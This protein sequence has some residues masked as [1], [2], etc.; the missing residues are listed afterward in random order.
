[1][2]LVKLKNQHKY[3]SSCH[4]RWIITAKT[5]CYPWHKYSDCGIGVEWSYRRA[6]FCLECRSSFQMH[7]KVEAVNVKEFTQR[8]YAF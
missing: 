7:K 6:G 1:M 4:T 3:E 5:L 8:L 2:H